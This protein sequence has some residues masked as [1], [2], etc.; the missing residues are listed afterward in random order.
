MHPA[1]HG[2]PLL[3]HASSGDVLINNVC[4]LPT[5]RGRGFGSVAFEAVLV[6]A[7]GTGVERAELMAAE[8]GRGIYE[9][10]GFEIN[11][12]LAMRAML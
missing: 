5:H 1:P 7:R 2:V 4:T 3:T 6:W 8:S 9:K 11:N 12:S 10:A